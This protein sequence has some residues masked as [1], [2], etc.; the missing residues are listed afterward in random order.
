MSRIKRILSSPR[1]YFSANHI[2]NNVIGGRLFIVWRN[3]SKYIVSDRLFLQVYYRLAMGETLNLENPK[4]FTQKL[5]W[6]KLHNTNPEYSKMVDKYQVR[7]IIKNEIGEEYLIPLLGVWDNFNE[8]DFDVLPDQFVL[9][10]THNSG[11]V[12]ICKDKSNLDVLRTKNILTKALKQNYFYKSRE[13]PYKFAQPKIIAEQLMIDNRFNDLVDYKFFCFDGE[14]K[15]LL[16]VSNNELNK[17]YSFFNMN[18]ERLQISTSVRSSEMMI[19]Q[20][21]NFSLM[22]E[23][24]RKLSKNIIHVRID[25]YNINGKI[26]FGEYTFHHGGGVDKFSSDEWNRKFGDMIS[27]P[28]ANIY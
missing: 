22:I 14:P 23:I 11:T 9:K 26:F 24:A 28:M 17:S 27:L 25:L 2:I 18:F 20:P 6:L 4:T 7:E 21:E 1:H 13:Y 16:V 3:L 8:I 12:I 19:S 5:Q 15:I 10:T